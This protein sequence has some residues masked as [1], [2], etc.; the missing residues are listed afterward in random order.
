MKT[1]ANHDKKNHLNSPKKS[2][3]DDIDKRSVVGC[4]VYLA[5]AVVCR[6]IGLDSFFVCKLLS[7]QDVIVLSKMYMPR[8]GLSPAYLTCNHEPEKASHS[9]IFHMVIRDRCIFDKLLHGVPEILR[10]VCCS[11]FRLSGDREAREEQLQALEGAS[12]FRPSWSSDGALHQRRRCRAI[13]DHHCY[14]G[15]A[16]EDPQSGVFNFLLSS[17]SCEVLVQIVSFPTTS[18]T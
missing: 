15:Q 16:G 13:E 7:F 11:C 12:P 8:R 18:E 14:T 1:C 6:W 10:S 4:Y 3:V 17:L 5:Y 2:H 9:T